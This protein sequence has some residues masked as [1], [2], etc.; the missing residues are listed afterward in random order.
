MTSANGETIHQA[1][2]DVSTQR[3]AKVYAEALLRAA[4]GG[5]QAE[6]VREELDSLIDDVFRADPQGEAFLASLAVGRD[7]KKEVL[8]SIFE[9]RASKV[10]FNFLMV[11]NN[12]ERLEL[13]RPIRSAYRT[14][15][16]ERAKRIPVHVRSA[17]ALADDQRERLVRTVRD[18]MHLEPILEAQID[19]DLLGGVVVRVGDWLFDGSVRSRLASLC[20]ELIERSSHEIQ[21]RRD[22]FSSDGAD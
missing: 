10:F 7:R 2:A 20:N 17:V 8:R 15:L 12:H 22:R 4:E 5:G 14:L 3:V 16:N 9:P 11:L 21:S 1:T 18:I 6:S 13:L 19:P